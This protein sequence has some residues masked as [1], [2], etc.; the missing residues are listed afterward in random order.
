MPTF[1][2]IS[3]RR[4]QLAPRSRLVRQCNECEFTSPTS[5]EFK[6]HMKFEHDHEHIFLCEICRYYSLSAFE[7]QLHL[8][9]HQ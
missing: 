7:Y 4:K 9:S 3:F 5:S 8:Q 6:T 2:V 1:T